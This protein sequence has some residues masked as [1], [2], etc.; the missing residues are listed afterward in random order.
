MGENC[1]YWQQQMGFW[2]TK[3][4]LFFVIY[5]ATESFIILSVSSTSDAYD[6][7]IL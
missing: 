2:L 6:K 5:K 4:G 7:D 3:I 1:F